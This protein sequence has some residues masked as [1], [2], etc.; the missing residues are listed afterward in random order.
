[1][2]AQRPGAVKSRDTAVHA[3]G[4]DL[5]RALFA[6]LPAVVLGAACG[7]REA[8]SASGALVTDK[9]LVEGRLVHV[10][11][12]PWDGGRSA[13]LFDA[14][15]ATLARTENANPA[16][17][18]FRLP[19]PRPLKGVSI[20]MGGRDFTVTAT[21]R[22][23]GGGSPRTYTREFRQMPPDPTLDLEFHT[24]ETKIESL[25]VEIL[26][27]NGGDGHLHIRTVRLL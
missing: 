14:D 27:V 17:L 19:A 21:V 9:A 6:L 5:K 25:R 16:V 15:P 11:H 8:P 3:R 2:I 20:T 24:G 26:D 4:P 10:A 1:M 22:P 23:E 7:R 13:D 12:S 18:E